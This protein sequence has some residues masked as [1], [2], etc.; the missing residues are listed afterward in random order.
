[1]FAS[2]ERK[3]KI[4]FLDQIQNIEDPLQYVWTCIMDKLQL[5]FN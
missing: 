5:K 2:I 3:T 4:V 1:M